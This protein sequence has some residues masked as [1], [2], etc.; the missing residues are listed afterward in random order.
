M[1]LSS[2][3][4]TGYF[5]LHLLNYLCLHLLNFG[6]ASL[7]RTIFMDILSVCDLGSKTSLLSKSV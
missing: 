7:R 6:L 5:C 2:L 1:L 3:F 4:K